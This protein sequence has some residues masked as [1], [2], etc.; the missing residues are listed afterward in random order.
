MR[1]PLLLLL[2]LP[3]GVSSSGRSR[4]TEEAGPVQAVL[5][6]IARD[7]TSNNRSALVAR[8]DKRGAFFLSNWGAELIPFD[9]LPTQVYGADWAP[10]VQFAWRNVHIEALGPRNSVAYAQFLW[11]RATGD[12]SL[13]SYT[14]VF[15]KDGG[16]WRIR[17]EHESPDVDRLKRELCPKQ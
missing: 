10:P 15:A 4:A 17:S 12:S 8:Y 9:S 13:T 3:V 16:T 2:I 6:S 14:G 7:L 11:R 1:S 5:D